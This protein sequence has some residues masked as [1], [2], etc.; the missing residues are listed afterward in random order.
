MSS[1][2]PPRLSIALLL[3]LC[4]GCALESYKP[5]PLEPERS[6]AAYALRS[7]QDEGLKT[8]MLRHASQGT[9]WPPAQWGLPELTLLSFYFHPDLAV[10]RARVKVARAALEQARAPAVAGVSPLLEYHSERRP[11][12]AGPWSL[13]F[14]FELPLAGLS[15]RA[16][17]LEAGQLEVERAQLD[18]AAA[19]WSLR[20]RVRAALLTLHAAQRE[21]EWA[22]RE[23][24]QNDALV[25]LLQRRLQEG[26][27]SV[28]EVTRARLRA[29]QSRAEVQS[30][31]LAAERALGELS[32][33]LGVPLE[34]V[35]ALPLGYDQFE[36]LPAAPDDRAVRAQSLLNRLD[37]RAGLLAYAGAES[38]VKLHVAQQ[39]P[40]VQ[41]RPGYLWD[42]GDSVWSIGLGLTLPALL[43]NKRNIRLSQA[44]RE[45]AAREFERLQSEVLARS[46]ASVS[47]YRRTLEGLHAIEA[48]TALSQQRLQE[49][50]RLFSSGYAD[51]LALVEG[52]IEAIG[53]A[54]AAWAAR[55]TALEAWGELENVTQAP[56][57]GGPVP[58][59]TLDEATVPGG[60]P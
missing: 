16:A 40:E 14:E 44:R 33:S 37:I 34:V 60:K 54:K 22:E 20:A 50:E 19:A 38:D 59:V 49:T 42:Q 27:T 47:L 58:R 10:A 57:V 5:L 11:E 35:R 32:A 25:K 46:A 51:R 55:R 45:L 30:R 2:S 26:V 23:A 15:R 9:Q 8:F 7:T 31:K 28:G 29:T 1:L 41:L 24:D 17:R 53:A 18:V 43:G 48:Q 13:G 21:G 52:R 12:D 39:Y 56:L 3:V 36:S 4:T 6:A